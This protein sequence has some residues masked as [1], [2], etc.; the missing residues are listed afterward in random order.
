QRWLSHV[1]V[2][3]RQAPNKRKPD[4][5]ESGFFRLSPSA[6]VKTAHFTLRKRTVLT[7]FAVGSLLHD[8]HL[9]QKKRTHFARCR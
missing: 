1:K 4:S 6:V 9:A 7:A 5:K 2:G 3:H 8:I